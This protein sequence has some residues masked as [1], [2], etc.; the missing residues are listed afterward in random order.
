MTLF[1]EGGPRTGKLLRH[2][3]RR[4]RTAPSRRGRL[5]ERIRAAL[6]RPRAVVFTDT[7]GFT[8]RTA[9]DGILHCLMLFARLADGAR[10]AVRRCGGEIVKMEG[11][12]WLLRFDDVAAACEGVAALEA[13]IARANRGRPENEQ[14]HFS[15]GIGYGDV[16][17]LETD[18]YGLEVN[19]ASKIGRELAHPG[20]VLMTPA[21]AATLDRKALRRVVPHRIMTFENAAVPIQRLRLPRR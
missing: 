6:F 20:E 21:A 14:L 17:D 18:I 1:R 15:Y 19:L 12:S 3:K 8:V 4:A 10:K 11:D 2:L 7:S 5:D 13:A 16:L 9:R